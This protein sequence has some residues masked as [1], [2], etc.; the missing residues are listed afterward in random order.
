MED[1]HIS[2][3]NLATGAAVERFNLALTQVLENILD[4]NTD[5]KVKR[6]IVLKV[7]IKPTEDRASGRVEVTTATK[8]ANYKAV[9]TT[10]YIGTVGGE[11]AA[12]E[13]N[14]KQ[15]RFDE[16][17]RQAESSSKGVQ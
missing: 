13:H 10:I 2:L 17:V 14:P 12:V 3:E 6:E 5:A 16:V 1:N 11:V 15:M 7:A 4:P 9:E 8:L